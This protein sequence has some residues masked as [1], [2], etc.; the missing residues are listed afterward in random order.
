MILLKSGIWGRSWGLT[1]FTTVTCCAVWNRLFYPFSGWERAPWAF[2]SDPNFGP[3]C[4]GEQLPQDGKWPCNGWSG[5]C[6][7]SDQS[8]ST[9]LPTLLTQISLAFCGI[10]RVL[11]PTM[12]ES[13]SLSKQSYLSIY[14]SIYIYIYIYIY[15]LSN[16]SPCWAQVNTAPRLLLPQPITSCLKPGGF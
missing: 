16:V 13:G 5:V 1:G 2:G 12:A 15:Y 14:L 3:F 7:T 4:S 9:A 6:H 10:R 11:W 8:C